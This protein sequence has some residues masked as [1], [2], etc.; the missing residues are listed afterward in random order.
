M[1]EVIYVCFWC[2]LC[3][4]QKFIQTAAAME[5]INQVR[6]NILVHNKA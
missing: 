3:V 5:Q 4:L 2:N 1:L 6:C